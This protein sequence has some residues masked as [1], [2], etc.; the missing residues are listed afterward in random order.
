MFESIIVY[1]F[2]AIIMILSGFYTA[3][4]PPMRKDQGYYVSYI[5][6]IIAFTFV[7][8]CRYD[9][10]IDYL[11]YLQMYE[12]GTDKESEPLFRYF[13][14]YMSSQGYHFAF[15]FSLWACIQISLIY[16]ALRNHRYL[17]PYMAFFLIFGMFFMSMMNVI[18]QQLAACVFMV[19]ISFIADKKLVKYLL[20][21]LIA[22]IFHRSAILLLVVYPVLAWKNDWFK[23]R[24][25]QLL[26]Y[27][28]AIIVSI[29]FA[30]QFIALL[31]EPF[32]LFTGMTDYE[33]SYHFTTL[34]KEKDS[35]ARF[36]NNS[37]FGLYTNIILTVPI[38]LLSNKMREF[39][40]S[41]YFNIVYFLFFISIIA[42]HLFGSSIILNRP[43]VYV[44]NFRFV[45][46]AFFSYYCVKKK[47]GINQLLLLGFVLIHFAIFL[48]QITNGVVN[49]S[50]FLFFWDVYSL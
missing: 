30:D 18:R 15:Y 2:L 22:S 36:G 19:A 48:N 34:G 4:V 20:C 44:I 50:R 1:S 31:E 37:G 6:P 3:S 33:D 5:I 23:A 12:I 39:Y 45:M 49:K 16:Y 26:L 24:G 27:F 8:G 43:F 17:F 38:I 41:P 35:I 7:F 9:V 32:A 47:E 29:R 40:N 28:A 10:G 21:V 42:G 25:L 11:H 46:Y 13:T 14:E